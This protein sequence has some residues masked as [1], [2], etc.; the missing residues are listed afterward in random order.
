M[1]WHG[2]EPPLYCRRHH[3]HGP[4]LYE[5][6]RLSMIPPWHCPGL[7]PHG[8][9]SSRKRVKFLIPWHLGDVDKCT[10]STKGLVTCCCTH[11]SNGH[12]G[13]VSFSSPA[14]TVARY[15]PEF[16]WAFLALIADTGLKPF[17]SALLRLEKG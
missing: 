14:P 9:I 13:L 1:A 17:L 10:S 2:R 6:C 5:R 11:L 12:Q 8:F 3:Q 16:L 4:L 15:H 7:I